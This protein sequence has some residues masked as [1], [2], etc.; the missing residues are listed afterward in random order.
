MWERWDDSEAARSERLEGSEVTRLGKV[1][2]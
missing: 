1:G 2:G